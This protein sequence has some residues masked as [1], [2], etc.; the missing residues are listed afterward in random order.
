M[1]SPEFDR[2]LAALWR[3]RRPPGQHPIEAMRAGM[4]S[5]ALPA[6]ADVVVEATTV[7]S[8]RAEVVTAPGVDQGRTVLYVHGGGY[9]MGSLATH[10]KLAGDLS[11]EVDGRVVVIDYPLAP[12]QPFP[13]GLEV[14]VAA[15]GELVEES[16]PGRVTIAG[17]SAGGGLAL[18]A[19]LVA[20]DRGMPTAAGAALLSPWIDL[21]DRHLDDDLAERDPIITTADLTRMRD[22]YLGDTDP[23]APLASPATADLT[24]LPPVLVQ[25]GTAEVLL[26]DARLL[27]ERAAAQGADVTVQEW[28]D[29]VHVWHVFAGRVPEATDAVASV[30]EF[31][32]G[33]SNPPATQVGE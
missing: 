20:R 3:N 8:V 15:L 9:V 27:A 2:L 16:D 11:R 13:A 10:R 17:D 24:G 18:A 12:E 4:D 32:R 1:T 30:A 19:L 21:R 14:V 22:W 29:M 5:T 25:V 23:D 33:R 28:P 26:D 31:L 6:S 7:A